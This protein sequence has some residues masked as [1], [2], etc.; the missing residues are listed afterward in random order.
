MKYKVLG[1][2]TLDDYLKHFLTTLLPTN[3]TY[4]YFV[5]WKRVLRNVKRYRAEL[6]LL[7]S[8]RNETKK[9]IKDSFIELSRKYPRIVSA[10]PVLIAERIENGRLTIF[11]DEL[12]KFIEFNFDTLSYSEEKLNQI[13]KF[14]EKTGIF[15]LIL[16]VKDLYDYLLGVEV[17]IDTNAR[18]NRSGK[19]FEKIIEKMLMNMLG[20]KGYKIV[21]QDPGISLY[22]T[23]KGKRINKHDFVIY[24]RGKAIAVIEVNFY[25]TTGSKPDSIVGNY[26]SLF[27]EAKKKNLKFIWITDGP[28]WKEMK[29][30]LRKA[31]E[32]IDW[33][34]NYNIAKNKIRSIIEA[35]N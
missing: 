24:K 2:S 29:H 7:N 25:N 11:D 10:L 4:S 3:K 32:E 12:D 5:D 30:Y 17:G 6:H 13:S 28:A 8:L 14:C 35:T 31:M 23:N 18:K 26:I 27:R 16:S 34:I 9:S 22:I 19:I 20:T 33:V 1:F 15:D 21:P